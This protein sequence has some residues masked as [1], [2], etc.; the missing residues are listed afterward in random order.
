[1]YKDN[2]S[3]GIHLKENRLF[4]VQ[5]RCLVTLS[6]IIILSFQVTQA[7]SYSIDRAAKKKVEW[8]IHVRTWFRHNEAKKVQLKEDKKKKESPR[9]EQ[10]T[11]RKYWKKADHPHE[12]GSNQKVVKR[13]K[14]HSRQ[15]NRI[16]QGKH[17]DNFVTRLSRKKIKLPHISFKKIHWP[18]KKKAS[19]N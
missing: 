4:N 2:K 7:Q 3:L 6:V 13:M 14:K 5:L 15:A 19:D 1:L 12:S 10:K 11:Q 8:K 18:W 9:D 16:N 17:P